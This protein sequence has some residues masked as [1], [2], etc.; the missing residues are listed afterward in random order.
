MVENKL[1]PSQETAEK[2][3]MNFIKHIPLT[4]VKGEG[5]YVWD[6][7]GAKYLDFVGGWAVDSLG[8]CPPVVV[9]ALTRQAKTL[10]QVSNAYYTLPQAQLAELLVKNSVLTRVFFSNSGAEAVEGAIKLAR[11]WGHLKLNGAFEIITAAN[12]FHGRTLATLAATGQPKF[13]KP[14]E[15]L[16]VGFVSVPFNDIDSIKKST[17]SRTCA[18]LL[19]P[20]Q[21]EGGVNIPSD[22]YLQ[23]VRSW[24]DEKNI[25]MMLDE[26]QTGIGRLGKLFGYEVFGVNP[27]VITLAKGLGS[28]V[29]IGAFMSNDKAAV[30]VP[31][32]HGSTYG[33]NPLCTAVGVE[34]LKYI[35]EKDIPG[36]ARKMGDYLLSALQGLRKKYGAIKDV[37][38]RGLLIA[39]ELEGDLAEPLMYACLGKGLM[40]NQLKPNLIRFIPPLIVSRADIDKGLR[41]LDECLAALKA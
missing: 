33:G 15:P 1:S 38:G 13:Q 4:L 24:C 3:L 14:Y 20:I 34:V 30:F 31:G 16:P 22:D 23:K 11:R 6:E 39:M 18:V 25:L 26:V 10:I 32:D 36:N 29:P 41:I 19:E 28:G 7:K 9:D 12:S 35:L 37:R 2:Y 17:S 8:H 5:M 21:G 27:D 40:I